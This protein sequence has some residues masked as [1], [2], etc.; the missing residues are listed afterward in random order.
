VG[1]GASAKKVRVRSGTVSTI[2]ITSPA[3]GGRKVSVIVY[4]PPGYSSN[5]HGRYPVLYLLHGFPGSPQQFIDVGDLATDSNTL[6]AKRE[7]RPMIVVM[8]SGSPNFLVDEEWAN[9]V[10]PHGDWE[11][12]VQRDLVN[13]IDV[14]YQTVKRERWRALGGLSEGAYAALN[15]DFHHVGEFGMIEG[16]S[17]YYVADKSPG[18]FGKRT[19]LLAYNSPSIELQRV[20]ARLRATH[21]YIW[22]YDGLG[23]IY[24]GSKR[25]T[26]A[27]AALHIDYTWTLYAGT[28]NWR[29]WRT[30]L[31]T[32]LIA[33]SDYFEHGAP[34]L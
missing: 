2:E 26:A 34:P 3:L 16:W 22:L 5:L 17:P 8:P 10:Q 24:R 13:A 15:I 14:K 1:S 32:A 4:L 23:E 25:F 29:L 20:A 28:H 19:A 6:I 18:L 30:E 27:L 33:A 21:T 12:F 31:P 9:T 11:T 7:I